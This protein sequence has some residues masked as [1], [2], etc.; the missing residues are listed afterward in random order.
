VAISKAIFWP[1]SGGEECGGDQQGHFL[2]L[3]GRAA[4]EVTRAA[5]RMIGYAPERGSYGSSAQSIRTLYGQ[6]GEPNWPDAEKNLSPADRPKKGI[7][8]TISC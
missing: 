1:C 7:I 4:A 3:F 2:V 6:Y 8:Q 5:A